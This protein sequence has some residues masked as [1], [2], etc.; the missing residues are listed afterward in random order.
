MYTVG[1]EH[2]SLFLVPLFY[3]SWHVTEYT[4]SSPGNVEFKMYLFVCV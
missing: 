2:F 1:L 4:H 3:P